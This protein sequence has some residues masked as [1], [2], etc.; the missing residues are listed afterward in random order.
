M[1]G[2]T[3]DAVA[4]T[5]KIAKINSAVTSGINHQRLRCHKNDSTSPAVPM[6][7]AIS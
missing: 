4:N 7:V 1:N 2:A 6:F 5:N 3:P